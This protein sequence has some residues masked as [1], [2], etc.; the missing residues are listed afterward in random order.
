MQKSFEENV[1]RKENTERIEIGTHCHIYTLRIYQTIM[2][3]TKMKQTWQDR[4]KHYTAKQNRIDGAKKKSYKFHPRHR[5]AT[6]QNCTTST[7]CFMII[8][9]QCIVH[10]IHFLHYF[11][12]F[13]VQKRSVQRKIVFIGIFTPHSPKLT[14][15]FLGENRKNSNIIIIRSFI[16]CEDAAK[17]RS[18]KSE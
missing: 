18:Y 9:N 2:K 17:L 12:F 1:M 3:R 13:F 11:F 8:C 10:S 15:K 5:M 4:N 14:F 16:R 6:P 7:L